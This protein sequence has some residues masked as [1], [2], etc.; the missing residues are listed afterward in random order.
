MKQYFY[1]S[2]LPR[3]GSTLLCNILA[4]NPNFCVSKSTSGLHDV[5]FGI[6]NQWDKL[7]EHQAAGVDYKQ[8]RR[9][10]SSVMDS[11]Y[12]TDKII[13]DKG[14]G[15]LSLLEM[16]EFITGQKAKIIVPVRDIAEILASFEKLWRKS[17]GQSQWN[18]EQKDYFLTQTV[19][20][21]CELWS[22]LDQPVGLAYNRVID[23]IRR[24]HSD[25]MHFM[26]MDSLTYSPKE[27]LVNIYR[28]LDIPY[29][30]HDFENVEQVTKEDDLGVHRIPNLH[31]IRSVVRPVPKCATAILGSQLTQ[32]YTG[33]E[34]WRNK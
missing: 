26:E 15:W 9:V 10:L 12:A 33:Q 18:I 14:R 31:D 17:T 24:G 2:G 25:C 21:R 28:F 29:F 27:T 6:R 1:I 32:K 5:L 30:D 4:Q 8:L 22:R 16:V 23:A 7:I 20:G 34:I 19:M 11:Y 13:I 3:S